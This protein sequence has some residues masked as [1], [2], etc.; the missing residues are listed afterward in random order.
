MKGR[1]KYLEII[2]MIVSLSCFLASSVCCLAMVLQ[3]KDLKGNVS[4]GVVK[5]SSD[6]SDGSLKVTNTG[7]VDV[8]CRLR[9]VKDDKKVDSVVFNSDGWKPYQGYYYYT[10]VLA[11]GDT[12]E[13]LIK[14]ISCFSGTA[15]KD[16][17]TVKIE[18]VQASDVGL[19]YF[20]I[21]AKDIGYDGK[22]TFTSSAVISLNNGTF[23]CNADAKNVFRN[24]ESIKYGDSKSQIIIVKN[25]SSTKND[26][27]LSAY[28]IDDKSDDI[29]VDVYVNG[30]TIYSG[31]L[32]VLHNISLGDFGANE[33][34][35]VMIKVSSNLGNNTAKE[36][37]T[38]L[39]WG[40]STVCSSDDESITPIKTNIDFIT[41]I[42]A[43][44]LAM[45]SCLIFV[46]VYSKYSTDKGSEE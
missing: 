16:C 14:S 13:P 31:D 19:N 11:V 22:D 43:C 39:K 37:I 15:E 32:S 29:M 2:I 6:F 17:V 1:R 44:G 38:S 4:T 46:K 27:Y 42:I 18:V 10:K 41:A 26:I 9:V 45:W 28:D 24:F 7:T 30:S 8:F 3:N 12:S 23:S 5:C 20:N 36:G 35:E 40:I 34:K 33:S 25:L 21:K